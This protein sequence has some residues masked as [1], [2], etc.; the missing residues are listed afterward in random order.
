MN[1]VAKNIETNT[2]VTTRALELIEQNSRLV[3]RLFDKIKDK[4][5]KIYV[6]NHCTVKNNNYK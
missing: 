3:E 5:I 4:K 2:K 1:E 6:K